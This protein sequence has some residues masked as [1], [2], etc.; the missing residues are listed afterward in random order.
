MAARSLVVACELLVVAC[1]IYFP[2]Q[3]LN[4]R[5]LHW[6]HSPSRWTTREVPICWILILAPRL[7]HYRSSQYFKTKPKYSV[8][9]STLFR[10]CPSGSKWRR[11]RQKQQ[12]KKTWWVGHM[13]W[14]SP[15]CPWNSGNIPEPR[16]EWHSQF[17]FLLWLCGIFIIVPFFPH[18]ALLLL[19]FQG[20]TYTKD[21]KS[22]ALV[23]WMSY[24]ALSRRWHSTLKW[25]TTWTVRVRHCSWVSA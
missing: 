12:S 20:D 19:I 13:T 21:L 15:P 10:S 11:R 17:C 3:G 23:S 22:Y 16:G 4:P 6:G 5:P 7:L 2:N 1:G 25:E 24:L 8:Q 18:G 14:T 9:P